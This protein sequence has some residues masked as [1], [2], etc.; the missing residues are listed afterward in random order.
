M[1]SIYIYSIYILIFNIEAI[2][3]ND[4]VKEVDSA[5]H[6]VYNLSEILPK[7]ST[8]ALYELVYM[9][10]AEHKLYNTQISILINM[11][12]LANIHYDIDKMRNYISRAEV[13][14][15][16]N[17][18]QFSNNEKASLKYEINYAKG[19]IMFKMMDFQQ[20][21]SHFNTLAN[22]L[23]VRSTDDSTRY[24]SAVSYIAQCYLNL[25]NYHKALEM[26]LYSLS[27]VSNDKYRDYYLANIY[28]NLGNI[29]HKVY[30]TSKNK[31]HLEKAKIYLDSAKVYLLNYPKGNE[32]L[33]VHFRLADV[34]VSELNINSAMDI[35][36]EA[37][38]FYSYQQLGKSDLQFRIGK[39][40]HLKKNLNNALEKYNFAFKILEHELPNLKNWRKSEV[41][42]S[43]ANL[44]WHKKNYPLALSF[45]QKAITNIVADFDNMNVE[46]LPGLK[47]ILSESHLLEALKIKGNIWFAIYQQDNDLRA[48]QHS[49][50][51]FDLAFDLI[52]K[53]R[54]NFQSADYKSYIADKA[55]S[56]YENAI[57]VAYTAL[58]NGQDQEKYTQLIYHY[59]ERNKSRLLLQSMASANS[60]QFAGV[61]DSIISQ[62]RDY[63]RKIAYLKDQVT[64]LEVKGANEQLTSLRQELFENQYQYDRFVGQLQKSYPAYF[65][66]KYNAQIVS[67]EEVQA[68]LRPG[69]AIINYFVGDSSIYVLGLNQQSVAIRK[70]AKPMAE[71]QQQTQQMIALLADANS[72]LADFTSNAWSLHSQ[73]LTPVLQQL[74]GDIHRLKIIPDGFIAYLPFEVLLTQQ[75][76]AE[77]VAHLPYA[78]KK[79]QISYA[80]SFTT[81]HYQQMR[82]SQGRLYSYAGFAPNANAWDLSEHPFYQQKA[83]NLVELAAIEEEVQTAADIFN[84]MAFLQQE[85]NEAT[86]KQMAPQSKILHISSHAL[87]HDQY[88]QY[89]G[90]VLANTNNSGFKTLFAGMGA[91]QPDTVEDGFLHIHELYNMQ[92]NADLA[93]LSACETGMGSYSRGEGIMSLGRGFAYAGCPSVLMSLWKANDQAS[94]QLMEIFNGYLRSGLDKDAALRQA[95]L[96]YLETADQLTSHPYFWSAFVLMGNEEAID[97][98]NTKGQNT[99]WYWLLGAGL[100]MVILIVFFKKMKILN[101]IFI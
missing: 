60:R 96:D 42:N 4:I 33:T 63:L 84:G 72:S 44:F 48:L 74:S 46:V 80:Y 100:I 47:N 65:Q 81:G 71:L 18:D 35:L 27:Y 91:A 23:E 11:A 24:G 97:F 78:L 38:D 43:I 54:N 45:A 66:L 89:S 53:M 10:A 51:C 85:A 8:Y 79:Y 3:K 14:Y 22:N 50:A 92:L 99:L 87:L 90:I 31:Y 16:K 64:S 19:L 41:L 68:G 57:D 12:W 34:H 2:A 59:L 52:D 17:Y 13:D 15:N 6:A 73:L 5:Y 25:N 86:F 70:I 95:K 9:K 88:P 76:T 56:I 40:M 58:Q 77:R 98:S 49:I 32:L 21:M 55:T 94:K 93:I 29:Y 83:K 67:L 39:L 75:A 20:A 26:Y 62:E 82:Q 7:D 37:E 101:S 69:E 61:P 30:E 28:S 36:L 1:K